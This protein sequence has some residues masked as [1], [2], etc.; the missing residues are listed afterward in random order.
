MKYKLSDK[1]K[2]FINENVLANYRPNIESAIMEAF[3]THKCCSFAVSVGSHHT[4]HGIG[5]N[6]IVHQHEIEEE[7]EP[8]VWY[9]R[10]KFDGNPNNYLLVERKT[11]IG[12]DHNW[13][14]IHNH[15]FHDLCSHTTHFMYI[16][17]PEI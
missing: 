7:V 4:V 6:I 16:E 1:L 5:F 9:E 2:T 14:D 8:Y 17:K 3:R 13:C 10:E 15:T 11:D 12:M